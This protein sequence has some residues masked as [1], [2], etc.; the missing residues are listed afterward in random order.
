M[1]LHVHVLIIIHVHACTLSTNLTISQHGCI[2]TM[3]T[4]TG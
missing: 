4:P 3:E 1:H 2:K